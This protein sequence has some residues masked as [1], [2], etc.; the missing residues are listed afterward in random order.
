MYRPFP[1]RTC[2]IIYG[3]LFCQWTFCLC[4]T[5]Y[6]VSWKLKGVE[7]H[8][9]EWHLSHLNSNGTRDV[10]DL[11]PPQTYKGKMKVNNK[12]D[13]VISDITAGI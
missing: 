7:Y 11:T 8:C 6:F 12:H 4:Q 9:T 10:H 3:P 13:N 2:L 5:R 1:K